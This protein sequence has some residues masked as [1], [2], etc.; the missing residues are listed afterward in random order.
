MLHEANRQL[1]LTPAGPLDGSAASVNIDVA[2]VNGNVECFNCSPFRPIT[3]G[4]FAITSANPTIALVSASPSPTTVGVATTI[5]VSATGIAAL[6][7]PTG[8]ITVLDDSSNPL[9]TVTLP[10]TSCTFT[11]T[12]AGSQTLLAQYNGDANY[13]ITLANTLPLDIAAAPVPLPTIVATPV[14]ALGGYALAALALAIV[15]SLAV[16]TRRR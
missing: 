5:T 13:A 1:R 12:A 15:A 2:F 9:C 7:A 6:G 11:P 4:T 10:G 14:P 16:R 3:A 8:S